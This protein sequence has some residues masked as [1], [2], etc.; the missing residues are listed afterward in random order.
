MS[1]DKLRRGWEKVRNALLLWKFLEKETASVAF[2]RDR[3]LWI[4]NDGDFHVT[5]EATLGTYYKG[6]DLAAALKTL[7]GDD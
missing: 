4:E 2:W 7:T 3:E 5:D 1:K 6:T